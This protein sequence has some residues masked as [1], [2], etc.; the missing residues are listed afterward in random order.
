MSINRLGLL[1]R[2]LRDVVCA[3][4]DFACMVFPAKSW[5]DSIAKADALKGSIAA[6]DKEYWAQYSKRP[7]TTT[8]ECSLLS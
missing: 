8:S 2:S 4:V 7:F 1:F 6:R 3:I 5:L